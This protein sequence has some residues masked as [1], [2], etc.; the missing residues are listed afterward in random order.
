MA[1][2]WLKSTGAKSSP[3][4]VFMRKG[5]DAGD[6]GY[7]VF[8]LNTENK[9]FLV[10]PA[11]ARFTS[12]YYRNDGVSYLRFYRMYAPRQSKLP[13]FNNTPLLKLKSLTNKILF[14]KSKEQLAWR[15]VLE[16]MN[17]ENEMEVL[18]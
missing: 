6:I 16:E 17:E 10:V 3:G 18:K 1:A 14:R 7:Y 11:D 8:D 9:G 5:Y 4:Y 12:I 2:H 15:E 13:Q